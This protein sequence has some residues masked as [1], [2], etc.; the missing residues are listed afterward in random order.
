MTMTIWWNLNKEM[1]ENDNDHMVES[2]DEEMQEN[3][4]DHMVES[5]DEEMQEMTMIIWWNLRT[6]KCK[7]MTM[8]NGGISGRGNARE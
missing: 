8:T 5:Q 3:D 7:R 6:R 2:Q 1:Q 4:N